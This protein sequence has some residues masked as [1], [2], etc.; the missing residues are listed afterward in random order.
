VPSVFRI[1][2]VIP[3]CTFHDYI[4]LEGWGS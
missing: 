3:S 4:K 2:T 1:G